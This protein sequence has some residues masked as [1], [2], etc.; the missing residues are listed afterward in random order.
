MLD[1]I[2]DIIRLQEQFLNKFDMMTDTIKKF[3]V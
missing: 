1:F 3:L 2:L